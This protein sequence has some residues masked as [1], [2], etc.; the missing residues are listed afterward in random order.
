MIFTAVNQGLVHRKLVQKD[1]QNAE[2]M[3]KQISKKAPKQTKKTY[4]SYIKF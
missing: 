4:K 3:R 1:T 2:Y